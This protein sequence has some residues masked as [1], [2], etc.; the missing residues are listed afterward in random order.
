MASLGAEPSLGAVSGAPHAFVAGLNLAFM[1][2]GFMVVIAMVISFL[3]GDRPKQD[4][5]QAP[6][7]VAPAEEARPN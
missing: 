2:A 7:S 4:Q 5:V 6:A 3:K 1:A